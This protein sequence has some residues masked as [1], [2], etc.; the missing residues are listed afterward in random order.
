M[1]VFQRLLQD[2]KSVPDLLGTLCI[3]GLGK[4]LL[5]VSKKDTR[6]MFI[7]AIAVYS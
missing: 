7:D 3:K 5:K 2:F 6:S 4:H 1:H